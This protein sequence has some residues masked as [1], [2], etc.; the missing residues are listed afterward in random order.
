[1][2]WAADLHMA[3][4]HIK[5]AGI[6]GIVRTPLPPLRIQRLAGQNVARCVASL[7]STSLSDT[8]PAYAA[9][10]VLQGII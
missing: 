5:M 1:M 3:L 4:D 9:R 2:V 6:V 7:T 8:L 10:Q